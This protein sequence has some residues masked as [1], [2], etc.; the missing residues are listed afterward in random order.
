MQISTFCQFY[1][2]KRE[3]DAIFMDNTRLHEIKNAAISNVIS[4]TGK[5]HRLYTV[6]QNNITFSFL[7][8]KNDKM[9]KFAGR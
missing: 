4:T 2:Q 7:N 8:R 6:R 1:D 5:M 9:L 3:Y